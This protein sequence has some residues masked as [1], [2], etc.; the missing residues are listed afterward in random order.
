MAGGGFAI[1]LRIS[2]CIADGFGMIQFLKSIADMARGESA[3]T[4]LPVWERHLLMAR[5]PPNTAYV[6][7]KL[8]SLLKNAT[9]GGTPPA[10]M[11]CRY[12]SF[13]PA[14][15]SALRSHV[16]G[17]LGA[18]CTRFE[19]LTAAIWRCRA[20]AW[21][22]DD[23]HRAV[24][25]FTANVRRRWAH[26]PRGYYG[27]ALVCHVVDAAAGELRSRPLSHAVALIRDAKKDTSDEHVRS[28]ADF[29]ASMR[30]QYG[31]GGGG[32]DDQS[33]VV[34]YD[35]AAYMVSDWTRLG[36]DEV[37]FGW[38]GRIGGGVTMPSSNVSFNGTCRNSDGGELVVASMLL[39]E[40]VMERF[41][42][43]LLALL[44]KQ[45]ADTY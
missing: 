5:E 44:L 32:D 6:Q 24:L 1:G 34:V 20:S 21:G 42:K 15:V 8:M 25:A 31:R 4:A 3:P 43:E 30:G 45:E 18:S 19:L 13:G 38:A 41:Q 22:F 16:P 11:V 35:E 33:P 27:N 9:V 39:P 12:F 37:D 2:H 14:E 10:S 40:G 36:E 29:M 28:T 26:I 17:D 23:D 7:R